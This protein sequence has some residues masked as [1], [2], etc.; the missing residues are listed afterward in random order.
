LTSPA[1]LVAETADRA[2]G[3]GDASDRPPAHA[4][5]AVDHVDID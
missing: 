2:I 5:K 1:E 3:E 4:T